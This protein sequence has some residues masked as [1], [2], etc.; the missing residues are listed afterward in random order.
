MQLPKIHLQ[1]LLALR[2]RQHVVVAK[3]GG[4]G[5][6]AAGR[7]CTLVCLRPLEYKPPCSNVVAMLHR[8]ASMKRVND[9]W[10]HCLSR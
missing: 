1:Q 7:K 9:L 4:Q 8:A 5:A 6:A 2:C 3:R 10:S